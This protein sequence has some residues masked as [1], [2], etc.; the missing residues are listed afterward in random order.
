MKPF[1]AAAVLCLLLP[2]LATALCLKQLDHDILQPQQPEK[3]LVGVRRSLLAKKPPRRPPRIG[4]GANSAP[5]APPRKVQRAPP[6]TRI[7]PPPTRP[8]PRR[9]KSPPLRSPPPPPPAL[10]WN[11]QFW[12]RNNLPSN[13]DD[14][15]IDSLGSPNTTTRAT[16][17]DFLGGG[18]DAPNFKAH[19]FPRGFNGKGSFV[20]RFDAR[21]LVLKPRQYVFRLETNSGRF[22]IDNGKLLRLDV[23]RK[24]AAAAQRPWCPMLSSDADQ[25][26][27]LPS[28]SCLCCNLFGHGG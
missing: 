9:R 1:Y 11:A 5:P 20:A 28:S 15:D 25:A 7:S 22:T 24:F 23:P 3:L 6:P 16:T 13:L 27:S 14:V 8:A 10:N 17:I 2:E 12:L 21:L 19:P 18:Y 26:T 4:R